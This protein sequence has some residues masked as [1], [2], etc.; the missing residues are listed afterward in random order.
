VKTDENVFDTRFGINEKYM[1]TFCENC[2]IAQT[3]PVPNKLE[4]KSLYEVYYNFGGEKDTRYTSQR[5]RLLSSKLYKVWLTVDGDISFHLIKGSGRLLDLGCNE[6]RGLK[7]YQ[8]NGFSVE[9]LELNEKAAN[10][11]REKGFT[12]YSQPLERFHSENQYDVCILSN[13]LEHSLDPLAMLKD[14]RRVLKPGGEIRISC[15]NNTSWLRKCF[16]RYWINWH[17]PFHIVHF[18]SRSLR[19]MLEKSGFKN[20]QIRQETPALWVAHS[21]ISFFFAKH[22]RP[23]RELRNHYLIMFL[24]PLIR[25]LFFPMLWLGN[26]MGKGDCLV[27]VAE[28]G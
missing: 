15:P 6:G 13:V 21:V 16:G 25:G 5:E 3:F 19:Q 27:V 18:S 22:G 14:V 7:I 24:M 4:L 10:I 26:L 9:G 23:T 20:I 12:V 28:R 11:A 17:V 2:E 8:Q 1:I